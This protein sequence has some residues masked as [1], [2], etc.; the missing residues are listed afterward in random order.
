MKRAYL[1]YSCSLS[2]TMY[3]TEC[4]RHN[5]PLYIIMSESFECQ[6]YSMV[7]SKVSH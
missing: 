6:S 4:P 1:L 3:N 2:N 7:K 5:L